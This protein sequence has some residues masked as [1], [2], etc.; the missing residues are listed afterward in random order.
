MSHRRVADPRERRL[1]P[2]VLGAEALVGLHVTEARVGTAL[3][4][5]TWERLDDRLVCGITASGA[6]DF[7]VS[8]ATED[9]LPDVYGELAA[10]LR[11]AHVSV[12]LQVHG[13]ELAIIAEPGPRQPRGGVSLSLAGRVDGQICDASGWLLAS[14]AADCVPVYLWDRPGGRLGLLHAGWRGVAAAILPAAVQRMRT[15]RESDCGAPDGTDILVHLGPAICG[16]CYEVDEPVL[17]ALGLSGDRALVDLRGVLAGQATRIGVARSAL[18]VS[19][20]CTACGP[21]ALHSH[22]GSGGRAGRMAAFIG[23]RRA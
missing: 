1:G 5:E 9:G 13:A 23:F 8:G 10:G 21:E 3:R 17:W 15:L 14:T 18:S 16:H 2:T 19:S 12:P 6:G 7:G 22:R 11:F 20:L 4:L